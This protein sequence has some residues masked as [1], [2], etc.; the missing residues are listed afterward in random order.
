MTEVPPDTIVIGPDGPIPFG[1][2]FEGRDELIVYSHM[3]H[4]GKPW[5]SQCEGCTRNTW[6]MQHAADA[7]YLNAN[8][9]TFAILGDGPYDEIA[10]FRD[11]MGYTTPWY[12]NAHLDDPTVGVA[13][14]ISC[15]LRRGDRIYLTYWTTGRGD[16]VMSPSYGL[17]DL[18]A[19]GRREQ[20]EDS[21]EGWPRFPTHSVMRTDEHGTP[22]GVR[23][24]RPVVQWTRPGVTGVGVHAG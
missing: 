8:G 14:R 20:W 16:E 19:Y 11:F 22:V 13:G 10:A 18:T 1:D 7:A 23:G 4:D 21:P 3:F 9:I 17:L 6:P 2:V 5:E 15:Y 12:S 24:G